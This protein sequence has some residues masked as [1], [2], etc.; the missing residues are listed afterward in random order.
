M[1]RPMIDKLGVMYDLDP[2]FIWQHLDAMGAFSPTSDGDDQSTVPSM[3]MSRMKYLHFGFRHHAHTSAWCRAK[4]E[5]GAE[6]PAI[7]KSLTFFA[8]NLQSMLI[9]DEV[10][11]LHK[12]KTGVS[13]ACKAFLERPFLDNAVDQPRL[14][15]NVPFLHFE[16]RQLLGQGDPI[17]LDKIA[18]SPMATVL[19]LLELWVTDTVHRVNVDARA[20]SDMIIKPTTKTLSSHTFECYAYNM[21][22]HIH[23]RSVA[24]TLT[25]LKAIS[26]ARD[27]QSW[28]GDL[29]TAI[30]NL[31]HVS[32][33]I[34]RAKQDINAFRS[35]Y[36]AERALE[37]SRESLDFARSA[38]RVANLAF[39]FIPISLVTSTFGMNVK[40]LGTGT[41]D[42]R[43]VALACA[44]I[45]ILIFASRLML[46]AVGGRLETQQKRINS[47][48]R[49]KHCWTPLAWVSPIAGFWM[50][51][52]AMRE[53]VDAYEAFLTYGGFKNIRERP[54]S[55][56]RP[57]LLEE[58][59]LIPQAC[60]A[61]WKPKIARVLRVT[62][63]DGWFLKG[64][65][66]FARDKPPRS[67]DIVKK[68]GSNESSTA[69]TD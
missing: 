65:M 68:L 46:Y 49:Y 50:F 7:G 28:R 16:Y 45:M 34:E 57:R 33:G 9:L 55:W 31:E 60:T 56:R 2:L 67:D 15:G 24:D 11:V 42:L 21:A 17:L 59:D 58:P 10:L 63:V 69:N 64:F 52:F 18:R 36:T 26:R 5:T 53:S 12:S 37:D 32:R 4:S 66:A 62:E 14:L 43:L 1:F 6:A 51:W 3:P 39:I 48:L 61:S 8:S 25:S 54:S 13:P 30:Q 19:P 22:L 41:A 27:T 23:E 35:N 44:G 38:G 47:F 40:Q 29:D 20:S